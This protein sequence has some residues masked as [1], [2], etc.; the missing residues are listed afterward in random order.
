VKR[1]LAYSSIAHA[2]YML[3]A[4]LSSNSSG[5]S[6]IL[7]YTAVYA[8]S[9]MA[10]FMVL[11]L[12]DNSKEGRTDIG[13]FHGLAKKQPVLA[14]AMTLAL[15]SMAGIPPLSGFMAKYYIFAEAVHEGMTGLVLFAIFMSLISLYY[16]M[17]IIIAM[18]FND[19]DDHAIVN[20]NP[21]QV[22][23]LAVSAAAMLLLGIFPDSIYQLLL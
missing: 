18:Y 11:Y 6:S 20:A 1:I 9:S 21:L 19:A 13:A 16:Y 8:L 23:L 10:A 12:V 3:M 22:G 15:L 14:V 2:G 7:Y 4:C 5:D 17:K